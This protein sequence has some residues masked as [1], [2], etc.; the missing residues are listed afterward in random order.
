MKIK[1][2]KQVTLS[3]KTLLV[4]LTLNV[5]EPGATVERISYGERIVLRPDPMP[6]DRG[7]EKGEFQ[8]CEALLSLNRQVVLLQFCNHCSLNYFI[9]L[10]HLG[11][12]DPY[13]RDSYYERR[14]DPYMDRREYSRERELYREKLPPE[15]E[16][17]RFERERYLPRERDER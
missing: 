2:I 4:T 6:L 5:S 8:S 12:R 15:Y 17:E 7:Y 13:S 9:L 14:S 11:P 1:I 16:R 10:E 3:F